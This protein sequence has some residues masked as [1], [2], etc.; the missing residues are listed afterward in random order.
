MRS[1]RDLRRSDVGR[2]GFTLIELLVSVSII[3][4]LIG[5]LLPAIAASREAARHV[6]CSDNLRQM[7]LALNQY[8]A[9]HQTYPLLNDGISTNA[10]GAMTGF[11]AFSVLSSLLPYLEQAPLYGQINFS[12]PGGPGELS[13]VGD[14]AGIPHPANTTVARTVL[15]AFTC[16]SDPVQGVVGAWAGANY[17]SNLGTVVPPPKGSAAPSEGQN[18]AFAPLKTFGPAAF[19]DGASATVA[20]SEKPGGRPGAGPFSRFIGYWWKEGGPLYSTSDQLV[21]FCGS[22]RGNPPSYRNDVGIAWLLP[23]MQCTYYNHNAG[24]NSAA[25]DCVGGW[26]SS[27]PPLDNGSFAARS[28]HPGG[29][30]AAFVDGHVQFIRDSIG[31]PTWRALGTRAGGEMVGK[32][33]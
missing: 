18:G 12:V 26:N 14:F 2:G 27:D 13:H 20:F 1:A 8:V 32:I 16:P 17:R 4:I 23:N 3:A 6:Q 33:D 11:G 24:P 19:T 28:Y 5:L 29:V 21:A 10:R 7:G 30:H 31:V 22:L 9:Q 25:P 15:A